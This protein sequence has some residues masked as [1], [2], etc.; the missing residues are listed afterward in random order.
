MTGMLAP[1]GLF[2]DGMLK[3][4]GKWGDMLGGASGGILL[5]GGVRVG[6]SVSEAT[7]R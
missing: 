6:S 7:S 3:Q 2:P 5:P 4:A 1:Y